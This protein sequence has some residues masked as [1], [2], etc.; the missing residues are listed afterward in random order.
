MSLGQLLGGAGVVARSWR[1]SE[2]AQRRSRQI[3]LETDELNRL[4]QLE[5]LKRVTPDSREQPLA[6]GDY[7]IQNIAGGTMPMGELP[8]PPTPATQP[9][10]APAL[11]QPPP[12][13]A[14]APVAAS[15]APTA[16]AT[17]TAPSSQST[18]TAAQF[19][20]LSPAEKQRY[21][22][23]ANDRRLLTGAG[24]GAL[25]APAA[26]AD[27]FVGGPLN[28]AATA[29]EYIGIP[30]L[31]RA[32]G[33]LDP[34][35][36]RL[37]R[38]GSGS[39]TPYFD[40]L[41]TAQESSAPLTEAQ[42]LEQL[43]SKD[44]ARAKGE[45][46]RTAE[47][48]RLS[49]EK[50]Q[51]RLANLVNLAPQALQAQ[52]T[53]QVIT[54]AQALGVDPVAAVT[55]YGIETDYGANVKDSPRGAKGPMQVTDATFREMK[56]FYT[57]P[58][59]IEQY[60]IPPALVQA[61]QTMA[62]G[63]PQGEI[64]A[65]LLRLKYNELIG[66]PLNLWGAGYQGNADKVL[67]GG[68]PLRATDGGL[69]NGDYNDIYINL[70]N[71]IAQTMSGGVPLAQAQAQPQ[72]PATDP[73]TVTSRTPEGVLRVDTSGTGPA[74][75]AQA[76]TT[77]AAGAAPAPLEVPRTQARNMEM[78]EFYLRGNQVPYELQ[79]LQQF[80][81]QQ[82][83]LLTQQRNE[84]ARLAKMYR[85]SGTAYG[86]QQAQVLMGEI[87][88]YDGA[89]LQLRQQY[90]EKEMYLQGMQG[91]REL[92]NANDPR[93]ISGVLTKYKGVPVGI[94]PLPNGNYNYFVNGVKTKENISAQNLATGALREFS[95]E[96]RAAVAKSAALENE[97]ALKLRYDSSV[98]S[99]NINA[100]ARLLEARTEG[101]YKLAAERAKQEGIEFKPVGDGSGKIAVTMNGRTLLLVDTAE[102]R[103]EKTPLG[104]ITLPPTARRVGGLDVG[105]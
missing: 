65:G 30:R 73:A 59:K 75:V 47:E 50:A 28:A 35:T 6:V 52:G 9:R 39:A 43:R 46:V 13:A 42:Y 18:L 15:S 103:Q 97:L 32:L 90:T 83:T 93:L 78:A 70:Y 31:G 89:L 16:P 48:A 41:R 85:E 2:D 96:A 100:I 33:I 102:V 40:R 88:K 38:V 51:T 77:Q 82:A 86:S 10:A 58:K 105:R 45:E 23:I 17:S 101:E 63:T 98:T 64:D 7:S 57:D 80:A 92:A 14:A 66:L 29:A 54:R 99:A 1:E 87:E 5:D 21:R 22:Q 61:A 37:P 94:Q 69:T 68:V 11:L 104:T 60:G 79:Q 74:R 34:D 36:E 12:V 55:L 49:N 56:K 25:Q 24:L 72:A 84:R 20:A 3:Q 44:E 71:N 76:P 91:L 62:R 27:V 26:A 95:S 19:A 67:K 53:Q 81:Q 4:R 8:P